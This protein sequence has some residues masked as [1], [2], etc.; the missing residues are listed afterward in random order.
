V[1]VDGVCFAT[2]VKNYFETLNADIPNVPHDGQ[3]F[4]TGKRKA[5]KQGKKCVSTFC[6]G[7]IGVNTLSNCGK[8]VAEWLDLQHPN[9]YTGHCWRRTAATEAVNNGA[10]MAQVNHHFGWKSAQMAME[11]V[12]NSKPQKTKMAELMAGYDCQPPPKKAKS[13]AAASAASTGPGP[14]SASELDGVKVIY[15]ITVTLTLF[16]ILEC[17]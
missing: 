9:L 12:A 2:V 15:K 4:Y 8:D 11:Y 6:D 16:A 7:P 5:T 3:L 13:V 10:T 17:F 14:A 1:D